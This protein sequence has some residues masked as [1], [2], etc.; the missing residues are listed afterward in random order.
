MDNPALLE[1]IDRVKEVRERHIRN[2]GGWA[3]EEEV[4]DLT[5]YL[6][7]LDEERTVRGLPS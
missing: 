3:T 5:N 6:E 7:A 4:A 1:E 2:C